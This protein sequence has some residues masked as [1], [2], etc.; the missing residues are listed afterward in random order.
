METVFVVDVWKIQTKVPGARSNDV[1]FP[2]S[3]ISFVLVSD[4]QKVHVN[5][6]IENLSF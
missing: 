4:L 6:S 2:G 3:C 1:T 5:D